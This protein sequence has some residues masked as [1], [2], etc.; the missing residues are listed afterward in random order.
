MS[1]PAA[2]EPDATLHEIGTEWREGRSLGRVY[3]TPTG[4]LEARLSPDGARLHRVFG[5]AYPDVTVSWHDLALL[6]RAFERWA[7]VRDDWGAYVEQ[8]IPP[9][10]SA[11]QVYWAPGRDALPR[12]VGYGSRYPGGRS[13]LQFT[14]ADELRPLATPRAVA[15]GIEALA[16][17][18]HCEPSLGPPEGRPIGERWTLE[19]RWS[20]DLR[21]FDARVQNATD[22]FTWLARETD[23]PSELLA[24]RPPHLRAPE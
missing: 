2:P 4:S 8:G 3:R 13:G 24:L 11:A 6:A 20:V 16:T 19:G 14:G 22:R 7:A 17:L 21:R 10:Q 9:T 5:P 1:S 23:V 18:W 15:A 12:T